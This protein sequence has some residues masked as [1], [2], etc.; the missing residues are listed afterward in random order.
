MKHLVVRDDHVCQELLSGK[1]ETLYKNLRS[2]RVYLQENEV[3]RFFRGV[4][5]THTRVTE[6]ATWADTPVARLHDGI[7]QKLDRVLTIEELRELTR[8]IDPLVTH[9][10]L[11]SASELG[12]VSPSDFCHVTYFYDGCGET[13]VAEITTLRPLWLVLLWVENV[14]NE[15]RTLRG[16]SGLLYSPSDGLGYRDLSQPEREPYSSRLPFDLLQSGESLLIP[17]RI[18][19]APLKAPSSTEGQ[20]LHIERFEDFGLLCSLERQHE[21]Q[22]F[23]QIGPSLRITHVRLKMFTSGVH[24]FDLSNVLTLS[25]QFYVGSCP[26]LCA[27]RN[28][29]LIYLKDLIVEGPETVDIRGQD[30]LVIAEILDETTVLSAVTLSDP[31]STKSVAKDLVLQQGEFILI[32]NLREFSHLHIEGRYFP[33]RTPTDPKA[34]LPHKLEILERAMKKLTRQI[35]AQFEQDRDCEGVA[36]GRGLKPLLRGGV[37][38]S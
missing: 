36:A 28:G 22:G 19:L 9:E 11:A 31:D 29:G 5:R 38:P 3:L 13:G 7:S 27:Y 1:F 2:K 8:V 37:E 32:S 23:D 10:I 30:H 25:A 4:F 17:E 18:L 20:D 24:R 14:S 26:V 33:T 34:V 12:R 6:Y 35:N 21:L 16:Y 15:P